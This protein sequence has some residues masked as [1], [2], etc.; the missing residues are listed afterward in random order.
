M[1]TQT[2]PVPTPSLSADVERTAPA[3]EARARDWSAFVSPS[4]LAT[5]ATFAILFAKP[6][7]LLGRDWWTLPEA[8][9]GLLLGPVAIWLAWRS[10]IREAAAPNHGFGFAVLL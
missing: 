9:H 1:G 2:G 10:G 3:V 6:L 4:L 7:F 8:G 5:A